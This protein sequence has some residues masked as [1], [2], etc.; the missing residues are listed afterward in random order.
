[1]NIMWGEGYRH[2]RKPF[3]AQDKEKEKRDVGL[4]MGIRGLACLGSGDRPM[5]GRSPQG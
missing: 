2:S 3:Q 1:M 4:G 5:H